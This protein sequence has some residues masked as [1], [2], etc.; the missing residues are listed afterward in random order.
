MGAAR[1]PQCD[2]CRRIAARVHDPRRTARHADRPAPAR[3]TSRRLMALPPV[4]LV[5]RLDT[6]R[7]VPSRHLPRGAS[8]LASIADDDAHLRAIFDLDIATNDRSLAE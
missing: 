1:E 8:V 6:H 7:L 4:T 3:R 2:L 5:R